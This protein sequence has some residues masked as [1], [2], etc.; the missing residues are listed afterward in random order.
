MIDGGHGRKREIGVVVRPLTRS[1]SQTDDFQKRVAGVYWRCR[2]RVG[3]PPPSI[4]G[5]LGVVRHR[6]RLDVLIWYIWTVSPSRL[7]SLKRDK[8]K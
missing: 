2:G 7:Y 5:Y 4:P 1:E 6:T 3:D 8:L